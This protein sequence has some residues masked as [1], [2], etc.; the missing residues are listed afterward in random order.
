MS[1]TQSVLDLSTQVE[2]AKTFT[3]DGEPFKLLTLAHISK[4]EEA[5]LM[6]LFNR[7][8]RL[9]AQLDRAKN[10]REAEVAAQGLQTTRTEILSLLTTMPREVAEALPLPAQVQLLNAVTEELSAAS[11]GE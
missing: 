1:N 3:V 9:S 7:Q 2:E 11:Q 8:E 10:D 6:A 5:R 4:T